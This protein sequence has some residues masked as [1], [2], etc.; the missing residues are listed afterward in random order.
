[1]EERFFISSEALNDLGI[2]QPFAGNICR[3]LSNGTHKVEVM[4]RTLMDGE[5]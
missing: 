5:R 1:M 4:Y 2:F 3:L